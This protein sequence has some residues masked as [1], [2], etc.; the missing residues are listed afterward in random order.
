MSTSADTTP[1]PRASRTRASTLPYVRASIERISTPR[2]GLTASVGSLVNRS[3][4]IP[5]LTLV[6]WVENC[7]RLLSQLCVINCQRVASKASN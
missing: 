4:R 6:F 1:D 2:N 5:S 3:D 7:A